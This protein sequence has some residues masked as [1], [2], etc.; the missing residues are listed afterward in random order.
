MNDF[1]TFFN[2]LVPIG[3]VVF[4]IAFIGLLS[5]LIYFLYVD[6]ETNGLKEYV[7]VGFGLL[8]FLT[9][10]YMFF[11]EFINKTKNYLITDNYIEEFNLLTRRKKIINKDDIKGFSTSKVPYRMHDFKQIIVY[12][13]DGTKI[14]MMQF[15]YFNFKKIQPV[16]IEK[17]YK[18]LGHESYRWK[19]INS[20]VYLYDPKP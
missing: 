2:P 11:V 4:T 9:V 17:G 7:R 3:R 8:L 6:F 16:L 10:F 20:R 14:D 5:V 1:K 19:W 12:L 18:Y 13:N 15:A